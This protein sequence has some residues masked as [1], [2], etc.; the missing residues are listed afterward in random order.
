MRLYL[1][2]FMAEAFSDEIIRFNSGSLF[3]SESLFALLAPLQILGIFLHQLPSIFLSS[4]SQMTKCNRYQ[5]SP[6]SYVSGPRS[7]RNFIWTI[8]SDNEDLHIIKHP[9][10]VYKLRLAYQLV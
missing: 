4:D 9:P 3:V 1:Q 6:S 5:A 8:S 10:T 7:F 2:A